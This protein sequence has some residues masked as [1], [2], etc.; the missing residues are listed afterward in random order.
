MAEEQATS[1]YLI[2]E[3]FERAVK[4]VRRALA[5]ANLKLT[6]ELNLS[7]RI[8]RQLLIDTAPC[9]LLFACPATPIP[10]TSV[11]LSQASLTPLHIVVSGRGSQTEIHVLRVM[12]RD[13]GPLDRVAVAALGELQS[14]I[15]QAIGRIGMRAALG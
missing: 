1:T 14:T 10:A 7:G 6:G 2:A 5:G 4:I 12:P 3:P 15:S 11:G 13:N 8:Q 9:L